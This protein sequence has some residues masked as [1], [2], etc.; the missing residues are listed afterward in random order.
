MTRRTTPARRRSRARRAPTRSTSRAADTPIPWPEPGERIHV[1]DVPFGAPAPGATWH[2]GVGAHLWI[3]ADL[4]AELADYASRPYTV[5]RFVEDGLNGIPGHPPPPHRPFTP[6]PMQAAGVPVLTAHAAAGKAAG[7]FLLSDD[8]G[9]GKTG[10]AV[11]AAKQIAADHGMSQILVVTDRPATMTIPHWTRT[12]AAAGDAGL[13]WAVTTYDRLAKVASHDWDIVIADEGHNLRN[14]TTKRWANWVKLTGWGRVRGRRPYVLTL[15]AT[16]TYDPLGLAYLAPAFARA[17]GGTVKEWISGYEQRLVTEGLHIS[18]GRYGWQWTDDPA[19]QL[20]DIATI[21]GWLSAADP[22]ALLRRHAPWGQPPIDVL[23]VTLSV[24]DRR[25]YQQEWGAFCREMDLA[26]RG[27]DTARGRAAA[28]RFRQKAG[29]LR[30]AETCEWA[31]AQVDAGRQVVISCEFVDTAAE[32]IRARL[33]DAGLDVACLYGGTARFDQEHERLRFQ[34]GQAPVAVLTAT[35]SLSLHAGEDLPGGR[36]ASTAVRVGIMHQARYSG[37]QGRQIVGRTHRDGQ[38]SPWVIAY[39][40]GTVEE[41]VAEVMS[42]RYAMTALF[43]GDDDLPVEIA[44][45]LRAD[46][47]PATA[48]SG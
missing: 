38:T 16:P 34:T 36:R 19:E 1:L 30:V 47:L 10:T 18:K 46:W 8:A 45:V 26:R 15:T 25:S 6:R 27:R 41:H 5:P 7:Q 44:Q 33:R 2:R 4:P 40:E 48:L 42:D 17:R 32:P 11:L 12:I 22:P 43:A 39:A 9:C 37:L 3:G 23:P 13:T 31:A 35:S 28:L 14:R 24:E 29:M 20:A 21:T